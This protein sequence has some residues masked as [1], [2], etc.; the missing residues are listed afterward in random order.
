MRQI[1]KAVL[2]YR[3]YFE[4]NVGDFTSYKVQPFTSYKVDAF[5]SYK[6]LPCTR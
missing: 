6:V 1:S 4:D 5:T 2:R 3:F